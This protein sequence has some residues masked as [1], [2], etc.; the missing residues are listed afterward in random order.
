MNAM[1]SE[2]T[3]SGNEADRLITVEGYNRVCLED[4]RNSTEPLVSRMANQQAIEIDG[5]DQGESSVVARMR[6]NESVEVHISGEG[7]LSRSYD[8]PVTEDGIFRSS[9]IGGEWID[10]DMSDP[11]T[12]SRIVDAHRAIIRLLYT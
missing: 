12:A 5:A 9:V 10:A 3:P 8:I 2:T 11:G 7:V 4:L 1:N 6:S